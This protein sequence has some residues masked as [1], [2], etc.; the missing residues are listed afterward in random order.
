MHLADAIGKQHDDVILE[1]MLD[2]L[3]E[4]LAILTATGG[5]K[6]V[7]ACLGKGGKCG[8]ETL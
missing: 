2:L 5:M 1:V 8:V 7:L 6:P 3:R 4:E